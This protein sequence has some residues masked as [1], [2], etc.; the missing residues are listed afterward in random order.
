MVEPRGEA[1]GAAGTM[2]RAEL[3]KWRT[4]C[5]MAST[6]SRW[7]RN[8]CIMHDEDVCSAGT[9]EYSAICGTFDY[10]QDDDDAGDDDEEG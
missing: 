5:R 4:A 2:R 10:E 3:I 7:D 8:T 1:E 9:G 6:A